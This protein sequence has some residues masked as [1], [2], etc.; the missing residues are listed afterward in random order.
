[1]NSRIDLESAIM[2]S[3]QIVDDLDLFFKYYG[4]AE[5]R[6]TEDEV[7]NTLLGL[8]HIQ[9]MRMWELMDTYA[10]KFELDQYCTDPEKLAARE[11]LFSKVLKQKKG[12]KK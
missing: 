9:D 5:K 2:K 10:R 1:M 8:K 3:W 7:L 11:E 12:K 4:D 6:M